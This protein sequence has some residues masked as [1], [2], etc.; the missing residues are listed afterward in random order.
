MWHCE[1]Y[2]VVACMESY[3]PDG[4]LCEINTLVSTAKQ[5]KTIIPLTGCRQDEVHL[6]YC[7]E[8]FQA[9]K[10]EL[11]RELHVMGLSVELP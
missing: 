2:E 1:D 11:E 8:Y 7:S 9:I 10:A 3:K 4:Y 5:T 6:R